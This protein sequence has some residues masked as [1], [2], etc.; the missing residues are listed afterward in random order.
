M[1]SWLWLCA[2]STLGGLA[3]YLTYKGPF[4]HSLSEMAL[5][6]L[7][8]DMGRLKHLSEQERDALEDLNA[9]Q[10]KRL[11]VVSN[12]NVRWELANVERA[13]LEAEKRHA[14]VAGAARKQLVKTQDALLE[15][16][17]RSGMSQSD[18]REII[19]RK[20]L[21]EDAGA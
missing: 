10:N 18:F 7:K 20:L 11:R 3:I 2:V 8:R 6:S 21:G 17:Q 12:R 13:I 9:L 19:G 5:R 15:Y 16:L 1:D 4:A 14:D